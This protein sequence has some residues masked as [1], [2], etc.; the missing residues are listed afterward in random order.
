MVYG[1]EACPRKKILQRS[2]SWVFAV[3]LGLVVCISDVRL[4]AESGT[5]ENHMS[6]LSDAGLTIL[7]EASADHDETETGDFPTSVFV[8]IGEP[9]LP[10]FDQVVHEA[11]GRYDVD[12][13]LILAIILEESQF[14]PNAKSKRGAK[15]LMQLM[16]I[17]VDALDVADVFN[18][19]ENVDAGTRHLRGLLDRCDGDIKLALAAYNA[20]MQNIIRYDG[21]PP[22]PETRSFVF[23][24][25]ENYAAIK[26]D[27]FQ[28]Q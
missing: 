20:G 10:P 17:T 13:D 6:H 15:G 11:A 26:R 9:E 2:M 27:T 22:F 3:S 28:F 14:N 18:P 19:R 5:D 1:Q 23:R 8:P 24:V 25:L 7:Y 4:S 21:I 16:P 12:A